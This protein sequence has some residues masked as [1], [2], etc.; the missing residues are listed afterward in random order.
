MY[1]SLLLSSKQTQHI[2]TLKYVIKKTLIKKTLYCAQIPIN[3]YRGYVEYVRCVI[4][5]L[6]SNQ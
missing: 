3:S 5:E 4:V 6:V 2:N 1:L